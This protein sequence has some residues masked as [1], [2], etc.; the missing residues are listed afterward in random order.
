VTT[1]TLSVE[2]PRGSWLTANRV[3]PNHAERRRLIDAL[4]LITAV[5]A[6][7]QRL[8][9][10][11]PTPCVVTWTIHY[12]H[13]VGDVADPVNAAPTTKAILDALVRGKWLTADDS[14]SVVEERFRR[15]PNLRVAG[16]HLVVATF[17]EAV[18]AEM[19]G[20]Q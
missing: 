20:I 19:E 4:H 1:T 17:A 12:P 9:N 5:A 11:I 14:R 10:N 18:L 13:G 16:V 2:V 7:A 8:P 15:G 3:I 6:R